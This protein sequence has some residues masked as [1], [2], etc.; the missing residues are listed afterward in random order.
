MPYLNDSQ[1]RHLVTTFRHIDRLLAG[2]ARTL[3]AAQLE[4]IAAEL[5]GLVRRMTRDLVAGQSRDHHE[6]PPGR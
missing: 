3:A 1:K 6:I 2:A 4:R 5:I